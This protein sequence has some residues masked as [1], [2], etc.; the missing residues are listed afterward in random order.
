MIYS[1][2]QHKEVPVN[3]SKEIHYIDDKFGDLIRYTVHDASERRI[4]VGYV[5]L[6]DTKNGVKVMYIKNQHPNLYKHFGQLADQIELEH[7][8]QRGI[9]K[10]Y[11]Y[12]VAAINTYITHFKRGKRFVNEGINVYLDSL[13]KHLSK[14]E[15]VNPVFE[16]M[17][18]MFMPVNLINII[19][20]KIKLTPLLKSLK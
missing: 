12:S 4:H 16:D 13:L 18:K 8:L 1:V 2:L 7:C 19:K 9:D 14:G 20:D 10:P 5:D 17:Q 15:R 11:I 6:Q 3:V